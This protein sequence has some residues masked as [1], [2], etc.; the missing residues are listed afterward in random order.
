MAPGR[1][2]SALITTHAAVVA[3]RGMGSDQVKS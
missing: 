1:A 3:E 2:K